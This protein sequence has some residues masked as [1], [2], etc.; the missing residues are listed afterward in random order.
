MSDNEKNK[1]LF[2]ILNKP[3]DWNT[4]PLYKKISFTMNKL[5][6]EF[7]PYV[8]KL[9]AKNI[10]KNICGDKIRVAPVKKIFKKCDDIK[11]EDLNH[12][13]IIKGAHSCGANIVLYPE[14]EPYDLERLLNVLKKRFNKKFN[15]HREKQYSYLEPRFFT[16]QKINDKQFGRTGNAIT[17]MIRCIHGVPY[18]FTILDKRYGYQEYYLYKNN[19]TIEKINM[20]NSPLKPLEFTYDLIR[21]TEDEIIRMYNLSKILSKPFEF[22]RMDYYINKNSEI[23]FSEFTFTP[24]TGRM[25][26]DLKTE[27]ML[28]K[29][30][31]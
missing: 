5:G 27:L 4:L 30:W 12:N 20:D 11:Q 19:K 16:E 26:Y 3:T 10:V 9:D 25:V 31:K 23:I 21:P 7:A 22:V 28:G 2:K 1:N 13:F 18:T 6:P 8:D 14:P 24:N 15:S 17:Y 29:L